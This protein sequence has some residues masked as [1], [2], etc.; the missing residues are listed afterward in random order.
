MVTDEKTY[1]VTGVLTPDIKGTYA[2]AGEYNGKRS[3]KLAGQEWYIWW[4]GIIAWL[5]TT[6]RGVASPARWLREAP[7]IEGVYIPLQDAIG[8]AT[9]T[10]I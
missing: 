7:D 4:D 3:Y 8:E 1:E 9:V 2:D 6:E 5:I 10:E